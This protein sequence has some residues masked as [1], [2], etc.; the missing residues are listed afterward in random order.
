MATP[1]KAVPAPE[2]D[3]R[4]RQRSPAYPF[5]SLE[6]AIK[7][8]KEFYDKEQR[9]AAPLK[10]AVRHWNYEEKSSGGLQTAAALLNFGLLSDEGTG[11]KRKVRLTDNALRI[12][13]DDRMDSP[14]RA[15]AIRTAALRPKIHQQLWKDYKNDL[16]SDANLKH[17]LILDWKPPFLSNSADAFIKE[18]KD[19]IAYAKLDSSVTVPL[20]G[21][22][23]DAQLDDEE[24][25]NGEDDL[26]RGDYVPAV[27]DYVQWAPNGVLQFREPK[28][29]TGLTHGGDFAFVDGNATGLPVVELTLQR[30]PISAPVTRSDPA[31]AKH[32]MRQDI[33]SLPEGTVTI[34]WPTSLSAESIQDFRDWLKIVER[35]VARSIESSTRNESSTGVEMRPE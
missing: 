28:R 35:K 24:R 1:T 30:R 34:Q 18:Y 31:P 2:N 33:F 22:G 12:L 14:E 20:S 32:P 3:K 6:P 21:G 29:I 11:E 5:I 26:A 27:G 15:E 25:G 9:N 17:R 23:L 13:L 10:V 16:P 4:K 8:A 19:T 7:R